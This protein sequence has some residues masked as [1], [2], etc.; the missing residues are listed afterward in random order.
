MTEKF[1]NWIDTI[2]KA[3]GYLSAFFMV[4]IVIL[5]TVEIFIRTLF[6]VSTLV[7][8]EY[9]AYFFVGVVML[10]LAFSLQDGAHIRI[11]LVLSR[12]NEKA[13]MVLSMIVILFAVVLCSYALYHSGLMAYDAY[14]LEMTADSISETPIYIPQLFIP[15][16]FLLFDLQLISI[17][18]RRL[19]SYQTR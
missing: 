4:L 8:D 16:G 1:I 3:G 13:E 2:A 9:S 7:A 10:G 11:T 18:L 14:S 19:L 15:L 5:I 6:G 12:L 17:F